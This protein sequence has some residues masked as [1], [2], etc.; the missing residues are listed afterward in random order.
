MFG[1]TDAPIK[2]QSDDK[3][4]VK[5][6]IIG[7]N[8]FIEKC[9]TP[10][11]LAIQGDWGSGKTSFMNMINDEISEKVVTVWFN[12]W[13][14]SQFHLSDSLTLTLLETLADSLDAD[15]IVSTEMKHTIKKLCKTV[16]YLGN[17]VVAN[18]TGVDP[19]NCIK[20]ADEP[21]NVIKDITNLKANFQKCIDAALKKKNKDKLV[22]FIDDLDRLPPEK[23]VEVLEVLKLFLD[24]DKCVFVLAIDYDVVCKGISKKYGEEFDAQKGMSFFDKII[25][26]PFKMPI[27]QYE[28][29]EYIE[30]TLKDM[31]LST[32][33]ATVF[34][35]LIS[36]SIGF[37]PRGMKRIFNAFLLLKMVYAESGLDDAKKQAVLF[38]VL[39]LQMSFE[40]IYDY[41]VTDEDSILTTKL[42]SE[43]AGC[44]IENNEEIQPFWDK[45]DE[46]SEDNADEVKS[47]M[48]AFA[49]AMQNEEGKITDLEFENLKGILK[50][51]IDTSGTHSSLHSNN[52]KIGLGI[53]YS[54]EYDE[55]F[56][57]H[58]ISEEIEKTN[59]PA[60]WNGCKL[61]GYRLFDKEYETTNFADL[62]ATVLSEMYVKNAN[63]FKEIQENSDDFQLYALFY[64][65]KK[66]G[67]LAAPKKIPNTDY[68]FESKNSNDGKITLL[69]RMLVAMG[70]E[71]SNLSVNVNLAHRLQPDKNKM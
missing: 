6:Y 45:I 55:Q 53:R 38:A 27:A 48:V 69:R 71:A 17:N 66:L 10:M 37:N 50:I 21:N 2:T 54:N 16:M 1:N 44:Y 23:A 4:G 62:V 3:F 52:G 26:V 28:I 31:E 42:M 5:K 60:G 35:D 65:S 19:S 59:A 11:T 33:N 18:F 13:Q 51:S 58:S 49:K 70:Y 8:K 22:V 9:D 61:N 63:K 30:K 36:K 20:S 67:R 47:F 43:L 14:F 32:V 24:C 68:K 57:Y 7:L 41:F 29:K 64:G 39:C 15:A 12:T 56:S 46:L 40:N 25:Q 34:T